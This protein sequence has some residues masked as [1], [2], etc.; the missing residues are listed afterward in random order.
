MY[1]TALGRKRW[2]SDTESGKMGGTENRHAGRAGLG[3]LKEGE[4]RKGLWSA[5][6]D[7]IKSPLFHYHPVAVK[8]EVQ[9]VSPPAFVTHWGAQ[10]YTHMLSPLLFKDTLALA[11]LWSTGEC[12][13]FSGTDVR[14]WYSR[15]EKAV[16]YLCREDIVF[17]SLDLSG[18]KNKLI[19]DIYI[20]SLFLSAIIERGW[21]GW[22]YESSTC[23]DRDR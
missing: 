19:H 13:L 3:I 21:T 4:K 18:L 9:C 1:G 12:G 20:M 8:V 5:G 2:A 15:D 17:S 11:T 10:W 6:G 16:E 14:W 23:I 22:S 7:G